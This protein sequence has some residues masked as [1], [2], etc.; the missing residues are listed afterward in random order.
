MAMRADIVAIVTAFCLAGAGA[1]RGEATCQMQELAELPVDVHGGSVT[2]EAKVN[3][4]PV[5]MI[6]DTGSAGTLLSVP[7]AQRLGL[8][9]RKFFRVEMYGVGGKAAASSAL[10]KEF[11][12]GNLTDRN[13]DMLV[14]GDH[15]LGSAQ[16]VLGALFLMQTDVEFDFPHNMLRL[17]K[18]KNCKGDQVVYWGTAYSVAPMVG[19]TE[20]RIEVNVLLNGKTTAAQ[21]D[22]G[23][24]ATMVTPAGAANAGVEVTSQDGSLKG[25]ITGLGSHLVES[26][27]GVFPTFAFGDETIHNARLEVADMFGDAKE[28]PLNSHIPVNVLLEPNMLIGA[29]FF[30]SHRVYVSLGQRKVYVSYVGG[31]VF[32]S[33]SPPQGPREPGAS[34][35]PIPY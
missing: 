22:T 12:V 23:S 21:M 14:T 25:P 29:D 28:A 7:A 4:Q 15:D 19:S 20:G 3:G 26:Y 33:P 9:L 6:V 17:F 2:L 8:V 13:F 31:P 11:K 10:I 16:G 30:R 34:G 24:S 1:V 5:R 27:S 35:A 32:S 18:P